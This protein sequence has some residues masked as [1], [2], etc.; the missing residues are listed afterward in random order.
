[1]HFK[2]ATLCL[3]AAATLVAASP[4]AVEKRAALQKAK[5]WDELIRLSVAEPYLA[6]MS[7][8]F[9]IPVE[10]GHI[11]SAQMD[12]DI[13]IQVFLHDNAE[14]VEKAQL[15][16]KE[17]I[18]RIIGKPEE[19]IPAIEKEIFKKENLYDRAVNYLAFTKLFED[20]NGDF[21]G[22][23]GFAQVLKNKV[24][25]CLTEEGEAINEKEKI[26]D[27]DMA[28]NPEDYDYPPVASNKP[29]T[30][31]FNEMFFN[32]CD[33]Y[34][35]S[36]LFG[37]PNLNRQMEGLSEALIRAF[38]NN[39]SVLD[40][41]I[42]LVLRDGDGHDTMSDEEANPV[43]KV[44]SP[45][46]IQEIASFY[47]LLLENELEIADHSYIV[48]YCEYIH[49]SIKNERYGISESDGAVLFWAKFL[50]LLAE[51]FLG[52]PNEMEKT[53]N[54]F[55]ESEKDQARLILTYQFYSFQSFNTMT[56]HADLF[57]RAN[58]LAK[59]IHIFERAL[60]Y[61][62]EPNEPNAHSDLAVL[63]LKA[64]SCTDFELLTDPDEEQRRVL[65]ISMIKEATGC[66][67]GMIR[68]KL[69]ER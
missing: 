21:I 6:A 45:W 25:Q 17:K 28:A 4:A 62:D 36:R 29:W 66:A 12:D 1:M 61:G 30:R 5:T 65:S 7:R 64:L 48:A 14:D 58:T 53:F 33:M 59:S 31:A 13:Q 60:Y 69:G 35:R 32:Y 27:D 47:R 46:L 34:G 24:A 44:Q 56:L 55:S 57:H 43:Q 37:V 42:V 63:V 11:I 22:F 23:K 68:S 8:K 3:L 19:I 41:N 16:I 67:Y 18:E 40:K 15:D 39:R 26:I 38:N 54:G 2:S 20:E 49:D 10:V 9:S 51:G 52:F 50:K